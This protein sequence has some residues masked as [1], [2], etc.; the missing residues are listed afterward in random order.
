MNDYEKK[1]SEALRKLLEEDAESLDSVTRDRLQSMR[2]QAVM[3]HGNENSS[4]FEGAISVLQSR[5]VP[6]A[7]MSCALFL[8]VGL[9]S[10]TQSTD[11]EDLVHDIEI[12]A[13]MLPFELELVEELEFYEWLEA[14]GYA[15]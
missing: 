5:L 1:T 9:W 3:S 2:Q 6:L 11:N 4:V 14:N 10:S 15:G 8:V 13:A 7:M 12:E